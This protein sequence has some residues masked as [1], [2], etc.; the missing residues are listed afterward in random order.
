MSMTGNERRP[1]RS[2]P[3]WAL[4]VTAEPGGEASREFRTRLMRTCLSCS[5][6]AGNGVSSSSPI[7]RRTLRRAISGSSNRARSRKTVPAWTS[8]GQGSPGREKR[9]K[10]STIRSSREISEVMTEAS[11]CSSE[12][13]LRQRERVKARALMEVRGLRISWATPAARTPSE[14]SFS[15]RSRARR[16]SRRRVWSGAMRSCQTKAPRQPMSARSARSE[17]MVK[18][19]RALTE[20]SASA[21]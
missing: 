2:W 19:W 11:T 13:G 12:P 5:G 8:R 10:S 1:L 20:F 14:A 6:S 4:R 18:L 15:R 3:G 7:T 17:P 9:R 16:D 21:R